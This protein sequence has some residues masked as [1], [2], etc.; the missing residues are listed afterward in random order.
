MKTALLFAGQATQYVGMG[1]HLYDRYPECR[2]VFET[3]DEVLNEPLSTLIFNGPD[4]ALNLT[5]NTQPAVLTV[6]LAAWA[7]LRERGFEPAVVAGHSLGEYA[8]LVSA[9]ALRFEDALRICR[10]RGELM[11]AAVPEG[12]GAMIIVQR[13]EA[14]A[15]AEVCRQVTDYCEISVFNAPKLIAVSGELAAVEAAATL[16]A[17]RRAIVKKLAVS[18]PFHC[19]MLAP[20]AIGLADVLTPI[21]L[22]PLKFPY[23][24]NVDAD[25]IETLDPFGIKDKLIRQVVGAVRW[26]ESLR[27]I[28]SKGIERFWH[29]GPGRSTL[30]HV[31]KQDRKANV[32]SFDDESAVAELMNEGE[33]GSR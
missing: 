5:R 3:A 30:T 23:V 22:E 21:S 2:E 11:Q 7:L 18:A 29:L 27:L 24:S 4:S 16:L 6:A 25:W 14:D 28:F 8:A 15:V 10:H 1:R 19:K 17:E 12:K 26:E 31:K 13:L 20:A 9:G 32:M 33:V